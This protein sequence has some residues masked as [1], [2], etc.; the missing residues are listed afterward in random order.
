MSYEFDF[1]SVFEFI[2]SVKRA[3][4][5]RPIINARVWYKQITKVFLFN[6]GSRK[7]IKQST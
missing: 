5:V 1:E 2:K 6:L 4:Y 3:N 7:L